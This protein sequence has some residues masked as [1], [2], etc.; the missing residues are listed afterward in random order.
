MKPS[1]DRLD[2]SGQGLVVIAL[3]SFIALAV[4]A[5]LSVQTHRDSQQTTQL[6]INYLA[7]QTPAIVPS[8][9]VLRNSGY[10]GPAI[11]RRHSPH[12]PVMSLMQLADFSLENEMA[13]S[14]KPA[15]GE[16]PL[17]D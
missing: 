17:K 12:L 13:G 8:G 6:W 3:V 16:M 2:T 7:L 1:C 11:D 10:A 14:L 5:I 4:I 9:H 15:R